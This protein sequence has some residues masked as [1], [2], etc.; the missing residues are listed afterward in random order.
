MIEIE[1]VLEKFLS[2]HEEHHNIYRAFYR[3]LAGDASNAGWEIISLEEWEKV[4]E[5]A[6]LEGVASL[7]FNSFSS[8]GW[9]V[10][11]PQ[12]VRLKLENSYYSTIAQNML[13]YKELARIST[14]FRQAEIPIIALKGA[15]NAL[16]LYPD[17][18]L[19]PMSDMDLLVPKDQ[20]Q[21]STQVLVDELGYHDPPEKWPEPLSAAIG[22]DAF[23]Y[24]RK[25]GVPVLELHWSLMGGKADWRTP[26]IDWFWNQ[27]QSQDLS[28]VDKPIEGFLVLN[29]AA[30]LLL[31]AAHLMLYHSGYQKRLIWLYDIHQ[32]LN[33]H[34]EK[35]DWD[36]IIAQSAS[37]RWASALLAS[38][39]G[40]NELFDTVIPEGVLARLEAVEDPQGR[41]FVYRKGS[42]SQ[43]KFRRVFNSVATLDRKTQFQFIL[44]QIFPTPKQ[45]R[46]WY[47]P[48][49][50]WHLPFYYPLRWIHMLED[51]LQTVLKRR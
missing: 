16:V 33:I 29:P 4:P 43:S 39:S 14:A 5:T 6:R 40:V 7:L 28:I 48:R 42:P 47:K 30:S 22:Y 20:L 13:M 49:K 35:L 24:V 37:F 11:M 21:K 23:L 34:R 41:Q 26:D 25:P 51:G 50:S 32:I 31:A 12:A 15:A 19:R 44:N 3:T 9:P 1:T 10:R 2:V 17:V 36:Q 8:R 46:F 45:I 38:L 27:V 18:G